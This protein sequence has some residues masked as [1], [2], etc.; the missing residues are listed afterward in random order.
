[1]RIALALVLVS[2]TSHAGHA[3]PEHADPVVI[4]GGAVG[5]GGQG[6]A[7]YS[8]LELRLDGAS[9]HIRLRLGGRAVRLDRD[10]RIEDL[11]G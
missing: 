7:A 8:A 2:T 3:D 4:V 1:M 6:T 10:F 9:E 11:D 5:A